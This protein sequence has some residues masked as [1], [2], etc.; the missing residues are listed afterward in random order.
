MKG[1][2]SNVIVNWLLV[3]VCI[4]I[5]RVDDNVVLEDYI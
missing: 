5:N 2:K 1:E 4:Y 3:Y